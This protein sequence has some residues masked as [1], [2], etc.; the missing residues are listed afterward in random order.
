[1][2]FCCL[3]VDFGVLYADVDLFSAC[4]EVGAKRLDNLQSKLQLMGIV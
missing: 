3:L 1:M 2:D 4:N